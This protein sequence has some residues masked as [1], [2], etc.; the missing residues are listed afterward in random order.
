MVHLRMGTENSDLPATRGDEHLDPSSKI[1]SK[2]GFGQALLEKL[3]LPVTQKNL[4]F[5]D[6]WQES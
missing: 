1:P 5:L 4:D 6:K 3:G 2:N